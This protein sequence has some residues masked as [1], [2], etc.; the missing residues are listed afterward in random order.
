MPGRYHEHMRLLD[1]PLAVLAAARLSRL[2][3]TDDIGRWWIHEPVDRAMDRYAERELWAAANVGQAPQEPW[4]WKYR[5]GLDCPF[6]IGFWLG[7][8]VLVT[9]AAATRRPGPAA[10]AWRLGAGALALNYAAAHLGARLGD[11]DHDDE[12]TDR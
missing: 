8:A 3:I 7:A 1:A 5:S 10:S 6:C 11:F 12:D 4:W 9:G 2:A